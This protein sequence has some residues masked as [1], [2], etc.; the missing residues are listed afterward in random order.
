MLTKD[1]IILTWI[2]VVFVK[3]DKK[4][5]PSLRNFSFSVVWCKMVHV[6]SCKC[7]T[8]RNFWRANDIAQFDVARHDLIILTQ[9]NVVFSWNPKSVSFLMWIVQVWCQIVHAMKMLY[10]PWDLKSR[11]Y[12]TI[13][14]CKTRFDHFNTN[15]C[16]FLFKFRECVSFNVNCT[17]VMSNCSC[18]ANVILAVRF[19]EQTISHNLTLQDTIWSF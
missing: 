1:F 13:W 9:I 17:S 2:N 6:M 18:N 7:Y 15:N 14:C 12:H 11:W 4:C 8:C 5:H 16:W 19:E 3:I 10:L